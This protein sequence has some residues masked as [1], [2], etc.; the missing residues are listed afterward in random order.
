MPRVN[1]ITCVCCHLVLQAHELFFSNMVYEQLYFGN[2][3]E[4][5]T[6]GTNLKKESWSYTDPGKALYYSLCQLGV[7]FSDTY[8]LLL[9]SYWLQ[10]KSLMTMAILFI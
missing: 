3:S 10:A 1:L 5:F 6:H 8:E 7:Y 9:I 4:F 2:K